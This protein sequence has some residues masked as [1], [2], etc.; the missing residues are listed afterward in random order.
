M[1][2]K[3]TVV[4]PTVTIFHSMF[5]N[6]TGE[7]DPGYAMIA[8]HLPTNVGRGFLGSTLQ[9]TEEQA[10]NYQRSA[11]ALLQMIKKLHDAGIQLVAGTDAIA[12]FTLHR[13]LELY[14]EAGISNADVLKI[15]TLD[16]AKVAGQDKKTG[17]IE[18]G[19][20]ADLVL[21]EGNPLEDIS[22]IRKVIWTIKGDQKYNAANLY[23]SIGIKPFTAAE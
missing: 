2:D 22:A 14:V 9:I 10:P 17:S 7:I 20:V 23:Q 16:S 4:D 1:K 11:Q 12:G 3:G 18:V 5:L 13:E 15:A 6:K 21:I 19:K 8:D